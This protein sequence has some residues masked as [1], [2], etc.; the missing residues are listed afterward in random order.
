MAISKKC[1][2]SINILQIPQKYYR[3][4]TINGVNGM[5][6]LVERLDLLE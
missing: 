5:V 2:P 1:E 4:S 6:L 3:T